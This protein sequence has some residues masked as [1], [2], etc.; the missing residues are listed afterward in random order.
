M[1]NVNKMPTFK[2]AMTA[3]SEPSFEPNGIT[4]NVNSA[5]TIAT[6]GASQKYALRAYAGVKSSLRMNFSPSAAGWSSPNG[7]TRLGPMRSWIHA[8]MRRSATTEYATIGSTT[9]N[10]AITI[11]SKLKIANC[12]FEVKLVNQSVI[13]SNLHRHSVITQRGPI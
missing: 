5:G 3:C 10:T 13:F 1:P 8:E 7:P 11:F 2:S 6:A 4:A 9:A 12:S